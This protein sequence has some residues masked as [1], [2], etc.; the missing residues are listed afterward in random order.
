MKYQKNAKTNDN[1][2]IAGSIYFVLSSVPFLRHAIDTRTKAMKNE[3]HVLNSCYI[4]QFI[5]SKLTI[6]TL[7]QDVKYVQS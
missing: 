4:H 5:W 1:F 2:C 3:I 6:G 7:E